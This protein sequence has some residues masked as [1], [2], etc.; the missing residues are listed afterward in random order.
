MRLITVDLDSPSPET[1][2]HLWH[3][4]ERR[5]A[6]RETNPELRVALFRRTAEALAADRLTRRQ[7]QEVRRQLNEFLPSLVLGGWWRA[8]VPDGPALGAF[9]RSV[10]G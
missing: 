4:L 5:Q 7:A 9:R 1:I 3:E 6:V 8:L 2:D 10:A